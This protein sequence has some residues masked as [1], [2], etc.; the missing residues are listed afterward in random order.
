MSSTAR[1]RS[2]PSK[3][4]R[5]Y[6]VTVPISEDLPVWPGDPSVRLEKPVKIADGALVNVTKLDMGAHTGTHVDAPGHVI[7]GA[8][9][10]DQIPLSRWMGPARVVKV[11]AP[12]IGP[13]QIRASEMK[14]ARKVLFKTRNAGRLKKKT[15]DPSY[16]A[17]TPA[18]ARKLVDLGIELVGIDY[19]SIE[20][21]GSRTFNAHK[22]L[23]GSDVLVI[24][25]LDLARV[26]PGDY[27]LLC[28][29]I[30]IAGGDG[31]PARVALRELSS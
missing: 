17:L 28:F 16:V 23:L 7:D 25:G 14:G 9:L 2:R 18:G 24:E 21:Y 5:L 22:I 8:P 27:E 1:E 20:R 3:S 26:P 11:D 13:R 29:P 31:A 4:L 19:L 10:L 6:D 12:S 30:L 15:F